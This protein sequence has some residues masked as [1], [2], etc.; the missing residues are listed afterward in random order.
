MLFDGLTLLSKKRSPYYGNSE[1]VLGHCLRGLPRDSYFIASKCGRYGDE[2]FDFSA[3]RVQKSVSES[4][5]NLGCEY[6]D[7]IQLHDIEFGDISQLVNET[8][9]ALEALKEKKLVRFI[10]IS[11]YVLEKFVH[12]LEL[13]S[14]VDTVQTYCRY[15]LVDNTLLDLMPYL[16]RKGIGVINGSPL[17]MGLLTT[18]GPPPWHSAPSNVRSACVQMSHYCRQND[19]N[20]SALAMRYAVQ[21][22]QPMLTLTGAKT[23]EMLRMNVK[24]ASDRSNPAAYKKLLQGLFRIAKGEPETTVVK[25]NGAHNWIC[26][27][28]HD[29][30]GQEA[31]TGEVRK[32]KGVGD[33]DDAGGLIL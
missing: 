5:A 12:V 6:L 20:I 30:G 29:L 1:I 8:L 4:I 26:A 24:A 18:S 31:G 7:L 11:S 17:S 13:S 23:R 10:G 32:E 21:S 3:E 28:N 19:A 33:D 27:L 16:K 22:G 25:V 15:S 9:P 14:V 2:D